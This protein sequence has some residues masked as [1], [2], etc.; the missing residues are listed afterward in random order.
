M[1]F[2][3]QK[4]ANFMKA[5]KDYIAKNDTDVIF[6]M[7]KPK[8]KKAILPKPVELEKIK[9]ADVDEYLAEVD[10]RLKKYSTL[11]EKFKDIPNVEAII[12]RYDVWGMLSNISLS[13]SPRIKKK[14]GI[15]HELF[16]AFYN[17]DL[18]KPYNSL[19]HDLEPGSMG[20]VLYFKPEP[21]SVILA[22]PPYTTEWIKWTI[23][24]ILDEWKD[25]ATFYVVIPVWDCK[26][27]K[28]LKLTKYSCF[29]DIQDLISNAKEYKLAERFPFFDG[30]HNKE[31]AL[32]DPIHVI[33]I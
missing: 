31:V 28:E 30:I 18:T 1:V 29:Y 2:S 11:Y 12:Y 22:N 8:S 9:D 7:V 23:R 25:I 10:K 6:A 33:K 17:V 15:T 26:T 3:V 14:W 20:N 16:G 4:E 13:V 32:K 21:G 19:F 27:R 24:K 5:V